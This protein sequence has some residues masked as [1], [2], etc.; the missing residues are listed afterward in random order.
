MTK[1]IDQFF[2]IYSVYY[3]VEID[4]IQYIGKKWGSDTDD[5]SSDTDDDT[6][7]DSSNTDDDSS[8]EV[9]TCAYVFT[10]GPRKN[11]SCVGRVD[12]KCYCSLHAGCEGTG[13]KMKKG[14]AIPTNCK[15]RGTIA[16]EKGV[17]I[18][19]VKHRSQDFFWHPA[20]GFIFDKKTKRVISI[21]SENL[22]SKLNEQ[23]KKICKN[24]GFKVLLE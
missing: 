6:D 9:K 22:I 1:S 21:Y 12:N 10:K 19:I 15:T 17:S 14:H 13:Q 3:N 2:E 16:D 24:Y 18:Y 5:D 20:S 8:D 11:Q 7:D 23:D 4:D